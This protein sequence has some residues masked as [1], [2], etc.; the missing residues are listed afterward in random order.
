[1]ENRHLVLIVTCLLLTPSMAKTQQAPK[2]NIGQIFF[3]PKIQSNFVPER[4]IVIWVPKDYDKK[5]KYAVLYVH[6]GQM[7]FDSTITWNHQE[8][9]FDETAQDLIDKKKIIDFIVVGIYNG[10]ADRHREYC[11]QKPFESLAIHYQDSLINVVRR[12][13]GNNLF[14]GKVASDE[15]LNFIVKELKPYIDNQFSTHKDKS[16]TFI[17]GSSMGGLISIYAICEY[18]RVFGGAICMSTH[19]PLSFKAENNPFPTAMLDYLKHKLP[20][21][22]NHKLYF[23]Y[24]DKTLDVMYKEFQAEVDVCIKQKGYETKNWKTMFFIGDD[25]SELS[26]KKR[27]PTALE[28]MLKE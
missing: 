20:S 28:F 19:W 10:G 21:A 1:M 26:W 17:G 4:D 27:L 15:Y 12:Q 14:S 3:Y 8:W 6:D 11:P 24:G 7:L 13:N 2:T 5:K 22:R 9:G 18:P 23:D 16:H 25:H